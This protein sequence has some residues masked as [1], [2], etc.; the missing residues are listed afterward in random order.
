MSGGLKVGSGVGTAAGVVVLFE[1]GLEGRRVVLGLVAEGRTSAG[2]EIGVVLSHAA[3][4]LAPHAPAHEC[5]AS[6]Q[7]RT[8]D[9]AD[10]AANDGLVLV[11]QPAAASFAA[12]ALGPESPGG[13]SH[14]G[15]RGEN[16]LAGGGLDNF[17]AIARGGEGAGD[18]ARRQGNKRSGLDG[19]R[20]FAAAAGR[21]ARRG[22][23]ARRLR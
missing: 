23:G 22:A 18:G 20:G 11:A 19:E 13:G 16:F 7:K 2:H 14:A 5:Y 17:L 21:S 4:L 15:S 8:A 9:T 10:Y 1:V 3:L 12:A 6:E